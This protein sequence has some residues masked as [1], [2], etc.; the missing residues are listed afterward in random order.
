LGAGRAGVHGEG[1][2]FLPLTTRHAQRMQQ[3]ALY[4]AKP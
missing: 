1:R 2:A 3:A 4:T